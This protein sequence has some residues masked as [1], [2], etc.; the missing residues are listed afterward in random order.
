M[1]Y[2][3]KILSSWKTKGVTT[4]DQA[5]ANSVV[6]ADNTQV[7]KSDKYSKEQLNSFFSNLDEVEI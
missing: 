3:N 4:L 1:Q 2:M 5:K 7:K 6:V